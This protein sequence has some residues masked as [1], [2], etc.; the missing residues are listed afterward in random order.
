MA[1]GSRLTGS[2]SYGVACCRRK[3]EATNDETRLS[4]GGG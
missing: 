3:D 1:S 4:Q 2:C